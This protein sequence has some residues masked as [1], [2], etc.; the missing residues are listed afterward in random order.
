[1]SALRLELAPALEAAA[2]DDAQ[3]P[4]E[5]AL[6][7]MLAVGGAT[8]EAALPRL[9]RVRLG[10]DGLMGLAEARRVERLLRAFPEVLEARFDDTLD[11][12]ALGFVEADEGAR[13]GVGFYLSWLAGHGLRAAEPEAAPARE[14]DARALEAGREQR[15]FGWTALL[16]VLAVLAGW[17]HDIGLGMS[18][19]ARD[20]ALDL[21][22]VIAVA[23]FAWSGRPLLSH[24]IAGVMRG[25]APVETVGVLAAV[26]VFVISLT[27]FFVGGAPMFG[28]ALVALAA[29]TLSRPLRRW[30]RERAPGPRADLAQRAGGPA[31]LALG[32]RVYAVAG[33]DVV[34][35]DVVLVGQ[36][37]YVPADG[38]V[39]VGEAKL[40]PSLRAGP[41]IGAK[42]GRQVE[43]GARVIG[44]AIALRA[45]SGARESLLGR[46]LA[47]LETWVEGE[48]VLEEDARRVAGR[49]AWAT[50]AAAAALALG[51]LAGGLEGGLVGVGVVTLGS[52]TLAAAHVWDPLGAV[53]AGA[54]GELGVRVGDGARLRA[55]SELE[56]L[57]FDLPGT[58][59]E[60]T[61]EVVG[62]V[63]RSD[64]SRERALGL[65]AALAGE[66]ARPGW[67]GLARWARSRLG[68]AQIEEELAVAAARP[69]GGA[70]GRTHRGRWVALATRAVALSGG[71]TLKEGRA[72]TPG[73]DAEGEPDEDASP[74]DSSVLY[75]LEER[76]VLA[77]FH[78]VDPLRSDARQLVSAL[79]ALGVTVGIVGDES[80]GLIRA[81]ATTSG[82][83]VAQGD[84]DAEGVRRHLH[85]RRSQTA[86]PVAL[87]ASAARL[88]AL[89]RAGDLTI[90][91]GGGIEGDSGD[92][93]VQGADVSVLVDAL[94]VARRVRWR[95]RVALMALWGYTGVLCGG[96]LGGWLSLPAAVVAGALSALAV[97]VLVGRPMD[98]GWRRGRRR[99]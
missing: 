65:L 99:R 47:Q 12:L 40:E 92:L 54:L 98:S 56:E 3:T 80:E 35:G 17:F 37:S 85:Q 96:A 48:P 53:A 23:V 8:T 43:A 7:E 4:T 95:A 94:S 5:A 13:R 27:V 55:F 97:A 30:L 25:R 50:L 70:A 34:P 79:T 49:F 64:V 28:T 26:A 89:R 1:M 29:V 82:A 90:S 75:L 74:A 60:G 62:W 46:V 20:I 24:V 45:L 52:A 81:A 41:P 16:A 93:Q 77:R 38:E 51:W 9:V 67:E 87:V 39:I 44:G 33:E 21:Q 57:H 63:R 6:E 59:T 2:E 86:R 72:R 78:L 71:V 42:A 36:G 15:I 68:D 18:A 19:Q 10:I 32:S 73:M 66:S 76:E 69:G 31:R 22:A 91:V 58:L 83:P 84:L 88:G 61:L 14:R 11:T